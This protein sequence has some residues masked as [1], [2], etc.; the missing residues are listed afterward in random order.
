MP[1]LVLERFWEKV[2]VNEKTAC[3]NW[4]GSLFSSGYGQFKLTHTKNVRAHKFAYEVNRGKVPEGLTLDHLCRNRKCVNP[5]HLEPVTQ[6]ENLMRGN[7]IQA[8]NS[9]KTHC[10][11]GHSLSGDNLYIHNNKRYC[12]ICTN[13][14][15][16]IFYLRHPNY[17][18]NRRNQK[19]VSN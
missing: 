14:T 6:K 8:M 12:K 16:R 15:K 18:K 5:N 7:S 11:K 2:E 19:K 1:D 4:L 3:W 10:N 9:K 17:D 13:E